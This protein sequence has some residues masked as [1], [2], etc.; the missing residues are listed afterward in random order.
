MSYLVDASLIVLLA[1]VVGYSYLVDKRVRRLRAALVDLEPLVIEFSDAVDKSESSAH[2]MKKAAA[3]L[4]VRREPVVRRPQV[5]PPQQKPQ[6]SQQPTE[7]VRR[8]TAT[9][10]PTEKPEPRFASRRAP[11][12]SV[13]LLRQ[14]AR[15]SALVRSFFEAS[16]RR[17]A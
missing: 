16:K 8:K 9:P 6:P 11:E 17:N 5:Q 1:G 2:T 12:D 14:S 7:K 13:L 4:R 10:P 3:D 15:K